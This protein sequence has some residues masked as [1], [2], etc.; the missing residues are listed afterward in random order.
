MRTLATG[1]FVLA[2]MLTPAALAAQ[3]PQVQLWD[4]AVTGDTALIRTAL[5]Q[6]AK[7]DSL[8]TRRARNGRRALNWAALN[9]RVPAIQL[10]LASG[11]SIDSTNLTGFTP[12]HHAAEMNS[13]QAAEALLAAG[14]NPRLRTRAGDL[15]SEVARDRGYA[16]LADLLAAA[17]RPD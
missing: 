3:D 14:A 12:L 7:V 16:E 13:R 9:N 8:D 10:L 4:G 6:G 11:A 1:L 2:L 15:P 5:G 17:E